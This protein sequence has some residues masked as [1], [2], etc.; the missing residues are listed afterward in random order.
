MTP[1]TMLATLLAVA[2]A[3]ATAHAETRASIPGVPG[4][5]P[6][7]Y[8]KVFVDKVGPATA[9]RVLVL[10]PGT[11]GG[12]ADFALVAPE[13]VKRVP[14]LQVWS[15]DRRSNALE[16]T[17]MMVRALHG[18]ATAQQVYDYYLGWLGNASIAP[19]Y[20]P[21]PDADVTFARRWGLATEM[22]DVRRVVQAARRG[23]R[24]VI[25]G[26]HSLGG[27]SV[28]D[29]ATWDFAGHA[30]YRDLAGLVLI[31]GGAG[32]GGGPELAAVRKQIADLAKGSPWSDLLGIGLPWTTGVFG[33]SGAIAALRE[34]DAPSV[35]QS[36]PLLPAALKPPLPA[37]NRAQFG[38]AF[39]ASTSPAALGLIHVHSG[40]VAP[41]ADASGLHGWVDDGITPI[42]DLAKL[43]SHEPGNFIE[44]YYPKRLSIDVA[45]AAPLRR[46]KVTD[47]LGLRTWHAREVDLPLYAFQ[48]GLSG[49][50]VLRSTRAF[51]RASKVTHPTLVDRS[52]SYAHV[53]PLAA[54]PS[55]NDFLRT[56]VPFLKRAR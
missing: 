55:R 47:F 6:A 4:Y 22:G 12:S 23:G 53:D 9:K 39:D 45:A 30:G 49:G 38:F 33:E 32:G 44:W 20:Q 48:T 50:R 21:V 25:L 37:T 40:H 35:G 10:I 27:A 31:D 29:Y 19:H 7:K 52:A 41:A 5:G 51:V 56:V 14:N 24:K 18:Q 1:R 54:A 28:L 3:P 16:D 2:I 36:S 46:T 11:F 15:I 17:S 34:P 42:D 26:G 43:L 8:A 13:L